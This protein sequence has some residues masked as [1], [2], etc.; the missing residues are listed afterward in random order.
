MVYEEDLQHEGL[1][2]L[3]EKPGFTYGSDAVLLANFLRAKPGEQVLDI[4][5]GTG[6]LSILASAKTGA[7]FTAVDIQPRM[8][9]LCAVSVR[10]N[11]QQ[12]AI[13]VLLAD[14]RTLHEQLGHECFDAAVCNPPYFSGGTQ[15]PDAQRQL[16]RHQDACTITDVALCA[17][18]MLKNGGR[19]YLCYPA[20][21]FAQACAA[22][23]EHRL[24]PKR[25]RPATQGNAAPYLT[26]IE[27]KKGGKPGL[28]WE[29]STH[30]R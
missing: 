2:I 21:L 23:V 24:E 7:H 22:L 18:R 30:G 20:P 14:I 9:E 4:G 8:C 1:R 5:C 29:E 28:V 13:S 19:L 6:I 3:V 10:L 17:K 15:S 25:V 26:L 12:D 11:G 27:A 16:S